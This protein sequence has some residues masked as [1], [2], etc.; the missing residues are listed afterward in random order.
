MILSG[1][2]I[3]V[4]GDHS[5]SPERGREAA[6]HVAA[7][8]RM[9]V[10]GIRGTARVAETLRPD[11]IGTGEGMTQ[12][13]TGQMP[14]PLLGIDYERLTSCYQDRRFRLTMCME[15]WSRI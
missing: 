8:L 2:P 7:R 5:K 13:G 3:P 1:G 11:N 15:K 4:R 14:L 10:R 12:F 9:V 6:R